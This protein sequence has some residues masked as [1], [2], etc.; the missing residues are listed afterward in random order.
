MRERTKQNERTKPGERTKPIER[1]RPGERTKPRS[2]EP[3]KPMPSEPT[4]PNVRRALSHVG[5]E[6]NV[7]GDSARGAALVRALDVP[8]SEV[9]EEAARAH[10]HGFHSYPA[11]MHPVTA[12]RLVESFS[13]PGNA[14]L[15]PFCGSGTVLVEARLVGRKAIGVDANPLAVRLAALKLRDTTEADRAAFVEAARAVAL[16]ADER[17]KAKSGPTRRYGPE[18]L[19]LFDRHVLLELDGVRAG[20]DRIDDPTVRGE[21]ELVLSSML[22]KLSRRTSDTSERELERRIAS[23]YAARLFVRKAEE[24]IARRAE[25]EARLAAAPPARVLEGDARRLDGINDRSV[26]LVVTSPPYPGVYDYLA[27]H[28]ARLRWLRLR[29]ERFER[30]EIGARRRLDPMGPDEG[31]ARWEREIGDTLAALGRVMRPEGA[32]ILLLADSVVAGRPV[33]SVDVIRRVAPRARLR[34][35]TV[36]SQP[37]PHFHAP[38]RS[39]FTSRPRQEH[40]ILLVRS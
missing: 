34:V 9:A 30:A 37:R 24:L 6:T 28:E 40:A 5:G 20:I 19:A 31:V 7:E 12:Q 39:A 4:K 14:V 13:R 15:D 38:T 17:R 2:S 25:V 21:L 1:R 27:H 32:A 3:T 26:D 10:V 16:F 29:P 23:G 11:R 35:D 22:T 33:Y 8:P 36:A 18:D